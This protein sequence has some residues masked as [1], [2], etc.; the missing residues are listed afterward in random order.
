[1]PQQPGAP[2]FTGGTGPTPLVPT[3]YPPQ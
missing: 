1:V 2:F 3:V